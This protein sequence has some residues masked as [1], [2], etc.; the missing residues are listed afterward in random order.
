[1]HLP[2]GFQ[3]RLFNEIFLKLYLEPSLQVNASGLQP[4]QGEEE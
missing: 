1:M 4:K 2:F 3:K